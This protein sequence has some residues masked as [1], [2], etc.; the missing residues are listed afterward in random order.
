M[1][2][3][4]LEETAMNIK[5]HLQLVP[6]LPGCYQMKNEKGEIIYVGKAKNLQNRL[7]SYFTG[8]HDAKTTRMIQDIATF[9]YIVTSSELEAFLLELN[10]IK[11]YRPK[12]NIL[13]MDDKTYPYICITG[14][15][16]P[17]LVITRDINHWLA[18]KGK[19]FGPYPN[20]K[21]A[22]DIVE[23]LNKI[24][25]FRKC[26]KLPKNPCLYYF[27]GQCLAP[28]I[29]VV[30][31]ETYDGLKQEVATFL[32]GNDTSIL[33]KI[34]A[35]M[36]EASDNLEF[37]KAIEYR[38]MINSIKTVKDEQKMTLED[39]IN[40]DIFGYYAKDDVIAIQVFHMRSGKVTERNGEVFDLYGSVDE[41]LTSY[42][43]QFYL[44]KNNV[45]PSEILIPYVEDVEL[46]K[47]SLETKVSIPIKGL[48]KKLVDLVSENAKINLEN[49]Q[50]LRLQKV[51]R[52]KDAAAR[53]GEILGIPFPAVMEIFDNSNIGGA[54]AVSA[55]VTYIDGVPSPKD[56]RKFKIRTVSGADD[57][58][59]MQEVI[60]RRYSR[61]LKENLRK[62]DLIL[63]DGGKPQVSAALQ[64]L[65]AVGIDGITVAG[66]VKDD[67]HRT[68]AL[69]NQNG[70]EITIDKKENVFLLLEAMQNEVHRYAISYFKNVHT[71]SALASKLDEIKGI[72]LN[73]KKVLLANFDSLEDIQNASL[74]KL[75]AL[76]FPEKIAVH[77]LKSLSGSDTLS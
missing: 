23:M 20:A 7:R 11:E 62:P 29:N 19:L 72:G 57:F 26:L 24:Y 41:A 56:Y 53:L 21:A 14:E 17:R 65:K 5:E 33:K 71:K 16:H 4:L 6:K 40:R 49:W 12:Y 31:K 75:K 76:G 67:K 39:K 52:T 45:K 43:S 10:F 55:M 61:V 9:E 37:E 18:K 68:R 42:I 66:I 36:Q 28:C 73:R 15:E 44:L 77:L 60:K 59:T 1:V 34:E 48:K 38:E 58:K 50:K 63:V 35:K 3:Y 70:E 27:L 25:P 2:Y 47:S 13:L 74:D 46:L 22:R 69:I 54:S 8:S 64:A 30:T 51:S 32:N